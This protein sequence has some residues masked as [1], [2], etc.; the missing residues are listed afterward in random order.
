MKR[1]SLLSISAWLLVVGA[2]DYEL[3]AQ[4]EPTTLDAC[5]GVDG[6]ECSSEP[7]PMF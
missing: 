7:C 1:Q 3:A 2:A 6:P 4:T 5:G